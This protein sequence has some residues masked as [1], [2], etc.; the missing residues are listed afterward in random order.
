MPCIRMVVARRH[1]AGSGEGGS[2]SLGIVA[3]S[4]GESDGA[5]AAG[6]A[7][8]AGAGVGECGASGV[9]PA[10]AEAGGGAESDDGIVGE[11]ELGVGPQ[12]GG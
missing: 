8:D 2:D 1:A 6:V 3:S 10:I 4:G 5:G 11:I 7:A 9:G 12:L